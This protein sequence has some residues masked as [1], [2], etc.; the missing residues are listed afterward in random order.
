M[1]VRDFLRSIHKEVR[2]LASLRK[3]KDMLLSDCAGLRGMRYDMTPVSG[4]KQGD[5][6]DAII[7]IEFRRKQIEDMID[8]KLERIMAKRQQA[9][10][11][12]EKLPESPAKSAVQ[13][14]YLYGVSWEE[15]GEDIHYNAGYARQLAYQCISQLERI[16]AEMSF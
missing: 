16:Q 8:R 6:S 11:L 14:H 4:G 15:V 10:M 12:L 7:T 13:E 5:L 2:Q 9:Y 3:Q 1:R